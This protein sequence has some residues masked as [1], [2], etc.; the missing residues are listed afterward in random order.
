[1]DRVLQAPFPSIEALLH[2]ANAHARDEGFALV[3]A[4]F[5]NDRAGRFRIGFLECARGGRKRVKADSQY[6]SSSKKC[7]CMYKIRI[8][9]RDG[10]FYGTVIKSAHNHLLAT[11]G[12]HLNTHA[13]N[14]LKDPDIAR[15]VETLARDPRQ[16]ART[17]AATIRNTIDVPITSKKIKS[18]LDTR[19]LQELGPFSTWQRFLK[20]LDD[21]SDVEYRTRR[22]AEDRID[23]I[24]MVFSWQKEMW[25]FNPEVLVF[26][27]TY[28]VIRYNM[29]L[30]QICGVS[31]I[32][33]NFSAG[34]G[35]LGGEGQEYFE[36]ALSAWRDIVGLGP[37]DA[38]TA[39]PR[40]PRVCISDCDIR[41]K[42]A[43]TI[44]F[45]ASQQQICSW[46]IAK[47][48][49]KN[50]K[51]NW[52]RSGTVSVQVESAEPPESDDSDDDSAGDLE[53]LRGAGGPDIDRSRP[54]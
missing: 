53:A 7:G 17:I 4:G 10:D 37:Y 29:P 24:V 52:G 54:T 35:L 16:S 9:V 23:G 5:N 2:A 18:Y 30:L 22:D 19:H 50:S 11:N 44:Y 43:A 31:C 21:D 34:F 6:E 48:V 33:S 12:W 40:E 51:E 25:S 36:F 20:E 39:G 27:N 32:Q 15:Q 8:N 46:H 3:K 47:N 13:R 45:P 26:D 41:Y 28:K 14:A 1:M 38:A 49:L 42:N